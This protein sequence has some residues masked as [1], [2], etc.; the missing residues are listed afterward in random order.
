MAEL[1]ALT[2]ASGKQCSEIIPQLYAQSSRYKLRL[3]VYSPSSYERLR[4]QYPNAE[5]LQARLD[6]PSD[7]AKI[8]EGATT[9]FYVSPTFH[10]NE[11]Q[12]GL[13]IVDAAVE[14]S[15]KPGSKF[16]HFIFSSVLHTHFRKMLNHDRKRE[17]EEYLCESL[18]NWTILQPSHFMDNTID[19]ILSLKGSPD[20]V[21]IAAQ[22]P[23]I[24]FS[25]SCVYDFAE[26]AVKVIKERSNHYF[27][28]YQLVST[29]P[30]KYKDYIQAVA[31]V[32]GKTLTLQQA[33]YEAIVRVYCQNIFGTVDVD[34]RF[35][36]GPARMLLFYNSRGLHGNPSVSE[37]LLGRLTT[38][39]QALAMMRLEAATPK[40]Q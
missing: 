3:A 1:I 10:P 5:V 29:W 24:S 23:E 34:L 16:T 31:S 39:P 30:M 9:M 11:V 2:C 6:V 12:F 33:P 14:E 17:V 32:I 22:N 4:A 25:F 7:C 36:E 26:C 18:L 38:S 37:W 21:Y 20:S 28:T 27:A 35:K 13:N 40:I 8:L 19:R 15:Q